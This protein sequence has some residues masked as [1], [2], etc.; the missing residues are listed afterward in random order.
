[1][2]GA[3]DAYFNQVQWR[4]CEGGCHG[5][6]D[7]MTMQQMG[8]GADAPWFCKKCMAEESKRALAE[9][10]DDPKT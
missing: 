2:G 10:A 8:M 9:L 1:M 5:R 7:E 6:Y 4:N 3:K